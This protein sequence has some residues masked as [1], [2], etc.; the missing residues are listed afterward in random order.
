MRIQDRNQLL[1]LYPS[2]KLKGNTIKELSDEAK[3]GLLVDMPTLKHICEPKS[4]IYDN[5]PAFVVMAEHK[6]K[7]I[8]SYEV[9]DLINTQNA[10]S[11]S[12][13]LGLEEHTD[14]VLQILHSPGSSEELAVKASSAVPNEAVPFAC[15]DRDDLDSWKNGGDPKRQMNLFFAQNKNGD[16]CYVHV[17]DQQKL[18][19]ILITNSSKIEADKCMIVSRDGLFG[20]YMMASKMPGKSQ[21]P[22]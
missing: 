5:Q 3:A 21:D 11:V 20:A 22:E 1:L 4:I 8:K 19:V 15:W 13:N 12:E 9:H 2:N 14:H 17:V 6:R 7:C 10:R 16:V 18:A